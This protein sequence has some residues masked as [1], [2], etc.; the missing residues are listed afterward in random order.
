MEQDYVDRD[1]L[2]DCAGYYVRCFKNYSRHCSRLHFFNRSFLQED[3]D[4]LLCGAGTLSWEELKESYLG[5]I[6]IKPL[7]RCVFGRTCLKTYS[8]N[9]TGRSYPICRNY[10]ANLLGTGFTIQSPAF[11]EQVR[12]AAACATREVGLEP[13]IVDLQGQKSL[14]TFIMQAVLYAHLNI[15]MPVLL[16]F[17]LPKVT[18]HAV[19][20]TE[21]RLLQA[22]CPNPY[23]KRLLFRC[24][25]IDKIYVHD[26]Q[27]GPFARMALSS[28]FSVEWGY[29]FDN[30][31]WIQTGVL[32]RE[33]DSRGKTAHFEEFRAAIHLESHCAP[34]RR[35]T[36][37]SFV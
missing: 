30:E 2:D 8:T 15:G 6:V 19:T 11:Q 9:G 26:D 13:L 36:L 29:L 32:G 33:R 34:W 17:S 31:Q 14:K 12:S 3:L 23:E 20:I 27:I 24:S 35:E 16:G 28:E 21:Y 1:F 10:V 25:R 22:P 37:G 5:F 4:G 7:P 18:H